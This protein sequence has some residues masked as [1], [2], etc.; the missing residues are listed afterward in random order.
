METRR[1]EE[2]FTLNTDGCSK[3]NPG[4]SGGGGVIRDAVGLPLVGFSAFF[5]EASSIQAEAL[6]LLIGL[7]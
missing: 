5:G 2:Y 7:R 3:G 6:A 4:T 1:R